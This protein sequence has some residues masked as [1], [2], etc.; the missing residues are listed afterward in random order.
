MNKTIITGIVALL[1]SLITGYFNV[2][3]LP[4]IL[5]GVGVIALLYEL[6]KK[7]FRD[8]IDETIKVVRVEPKLEEV[9]IVKKTPCVSTGTKVIPPLEVPESIPV[10]KAT[11]VEQVK[12]NIEEVIPAAKP[13]PK[14][15]YKKRKP[16]VKK[17]K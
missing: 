4:V 3:I 10:V 8:N 13:K 6:G 17:E 9:K 15:K 14:R 16:R 5:F 2:A 7:V 12:T 11:K 1:L